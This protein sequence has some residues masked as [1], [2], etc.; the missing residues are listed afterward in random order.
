M[1]ENGT[2]DDPEDLPAV[3]AERRED[4]ALVERARSGDPEAFGRLYDRWFDRTYAV[5]HR[6]VRDPASSEEV[7]Q[8]AFLS[9]WR[10]LADLQDPMAFGGWLLRIAR[11]GAFRRS[12]REGRSRAVDD[13]ALAVIEHT[14]ATAGNAAPAG[15]DLAS[16]L[17]SAADPAAAV[18]DRDVVALVHETVAALGERDAEVLDLQLRHDLSPAEIGEVI[19]LNRNAAN[20]LCHRVRGRF[21]TAFKARM[22][23]RGGTPSCEVLAAELAGAGVTRFGAEAVAVTDRHLR[24]CAACDDRSRTLVQPTAFLGAIPLL[25]APTLAKVRVADGLASQG[26]PMQGSAAAGTGGSGPGG[27][28]SSGGSGG[29]QAPTTPPAPAPAPA[30]TPPPA[31]TAAR[32][33][34]AGASPARSTTSSAVWVVAAVALV[35][36]VGVAA[37]LAGRA[38]GGDDGEA[39]ARSAGPSSTTAVLTEEQAPTSEP[40]APASSIPA[41]PPAPTTTVPVTTTTAPG[42]RI[43]VLGLSPNTPQTSPYALATGPVLRWEVAD[44]SQV[45]VWMLANDDAGVPVRTQVLSTAPSGQLQVC[46]GSASKG[47]CTAPS[48]T[49]W[50]EVEAVGL[51]GD[52]VTTPPGERPSFRVQL[53]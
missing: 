53:G 34:G 42:A 30:A 15:F 39:A 32:L 36:V 2:I 47:T 40:A 10:G 50:F 48:N 19:G 17:R 44:A 13:E 26:V 12:E 21:A 24:T 11:N 23:W 37:L 3:S 14:G 38:V 29:A 18:A 4:A 46:P 20:Q 22:L 31:L 1:A 51:D 6:I 7:C 8:D 16:S 45:E 25:G 43:D 9:A 33:V 5:V 52:T 41:P 28:S 35:V 27:S 49:Y